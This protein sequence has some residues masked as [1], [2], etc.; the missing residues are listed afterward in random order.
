MRS[1]A[2]IRHGRVSIAVLRSVR[3]MTS[4]GLRA[5]LRDRE[6]DGGSKTASPVPPDTG[7]SLIGV[8]AL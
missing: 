3:H 2:F 7:L 5:G 6:L 1:E 4:Y 8:Q